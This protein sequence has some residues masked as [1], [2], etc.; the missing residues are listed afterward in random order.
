MKKERKQKAESL[1]EPIAV[2]I[3]PNLITLSS[4]LVM[5]ASFYFIGKHE[6]YAAGFLYLTASLLDAYDGVVARKFKRQTRIG[7]FLD[8]ICDRINDSIP[9]IAFTYYGLV[10]PVLGMIALFSVIFASYCSATIEVISKSRIGEELSLRPVRST[11]L[12]LGI[13][14][15]AKAIPYAVLLVLAIASVSIVIRIRKAIQ[16]LS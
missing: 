13:T 4:V 1:L 15:G 8:R 7:A 16:V 14:M 10:Q 11:V 3:N 9:L 2:N 5:L 12:F 6:F